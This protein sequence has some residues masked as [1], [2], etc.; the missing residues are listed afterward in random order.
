MDG[1]IRILVVGDL[2]KK[3]PAPLGSNSELFGNLVGFGLF[4]N[5]VGFGFSGKPLFFVQ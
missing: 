4:G 5:L 3:G 1:M 2:I